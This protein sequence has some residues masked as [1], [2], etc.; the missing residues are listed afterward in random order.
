MIPKDSSFSSLLNRMLSHILSHSFILF[1]LLVEISISTSNI[2]TMSSQ[3]RTH[4]TDR[5]IQNLHSNCCSTLVTHHSLQTCCC[6]CSYESISLLTTHSTPLL[7]A[8]V[9]TY[10]QTH[11]ETHPP[12]SD[13]LQAHMCYSIPHSFFLHLHPSLHSCSMH[14]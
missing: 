2:L 3:M 12:G 4:K 11:T 5:T 6:C 14:Y 1:V 7:Y 9:T 8:H 10:E 13:S